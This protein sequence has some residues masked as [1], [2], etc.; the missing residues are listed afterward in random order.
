MH[1]VMLVLL[2]ARQQLAPR[3][4]TAAATLST[5]AAPWEHEVQDVHARTSASVPLL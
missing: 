1:H 2:S 5:A 3:A 4:G